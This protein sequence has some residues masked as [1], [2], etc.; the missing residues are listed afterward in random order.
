MNWTTACPDWRERIVARR[1][2]VPCPPICEDEAEAALAVFRSLVIADVP[3]KPRAGDVSRPWLLDFVGAVFG[4]YDPDTGRQLIREF[5]LAVSKKNAK[6]TIAA[7][8]MMTALIRNARGSAG[9]IIL[10]PTKEIAGNSFDPAASMAD[11]INAARAERGKAPLFRVYRRERRIL[12][13]ETQADLKVIAADTDTVGGTKATV[14]LVDELWL[15]GKRS[16]AMSMFREAMG[17][18]AARPEGFIIYL[19]TMSDEAPAGEFAAKLDYARKV[20][21]GVITDPAFLPVI[22]EFPPEM[23][24]AEAHRD[25]ANFYVTNPNLGASVDDEFLRREHAKASASGEAALRDFEAKHLNVPIQIGLSSDGW[26]GA[27]VW[28]RGEGGPRTLEE[29]LDRC[30]VVTGGL[31]GG[32]LDDLFGVAFIGREKI[33]RR[34]LLW[35][36][37]LI[38]PEGLERRRINATLYRDFERDGDL[39][40]VAGLPDDLDW[41]KE[42]AGLVLDAG[43]LSQIGA[44]PAGIGGAVDAL[45]EIGITQEAGLLIGVP[46]GIRLMNAAKTVERKLVDGSLLHGGSRLMAWCAGN[47]K[48]RATST[49]VMIERAASGA[50]KIDPLMAAF[51]AAHLMGLNPQAGSDRIETGFLEV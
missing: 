10:A 3:G 48:V 13:L 1:S 34:W 19:T 33:T 20:R 42:R 23:L 41:I 5:F 11:A 45:A 51:N 18:L 31:D 49:A 47:A 24:K 50:G 36:H 27:E 7:G 28:Q 8:I 37:A 14:V 29:L 26:A 40:V 43:V 6:S 9:F 46:Q 44:D 4:A 12:H 22:Y 15:F 32:G 35:A 38:S 30:D 16:G 17:G 39:T 21:D 25:P 2:L